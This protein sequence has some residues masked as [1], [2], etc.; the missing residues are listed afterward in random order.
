MNDTPSK[1]KQQ[2]ID[3]IKAATNILIAVSK[4]PSVD[5]LSA[6]I[7]MAAMLDK[8]GKHATAIFSGTLPAAISFLEPDKV[9]E[10]SVDSLRDFIIALD[11]EKADHVRVKVDGDVAKISIT[12]HRTT[13]TSEDLEFSQG[14]YN[15]ELVIALGVDKKD[16]LDMALASHGQILHDV[17]VVTLSVGG[18]VSDLGSI[19]W[20]ED[21][22]SCLCEMVTSLSEGLKA[23]EPILDKQISTALLTGIVAATERFSNTKTSPAVM[24]LA[25]QLMAAG[26]D[27]QLIASKLQET[28]QITTLTE[29]PS[30]KVTEPEKGQVFD[31][32]I[33]QTSTLPPETEVV[34]PTEALAAEKPVVEAPVIEK[35]AVKEPVAEEPIATSTLPEIKLDKPI[36]S[37]VLNSQPITDHPQIILD[38]QSNIMPDT[39]I[40]TSDLVSP[41]VSVPVPVEVVVAATPVVEDGLIADSF[42]SSSTLPN[43]ATANSSMQPDDDYKLIDI[44]NGDLDKENTSTL[45]PDPSIN[46]APISD[47]STAIN[48]ASQLAAPVISTENIAPSPLTELPLPPPL[49]D[50]STL[51]PQPVASFG[52]G[53][54][55]APTVSV[56]SDPSQF[57]IPGQ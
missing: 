31:L 10:N 2:I 52:S 44:F 28:H 39:S 29:N 40:K 35:P 48:S 4:D 43:V 50:F 37:D 46:T 6:A 57:K 56:P 21:S 7:G 15:V 27:Q 19:D 49:P 20:H 8:L 1:D 9:F 18:M 41:A 12:P 42:P 26:A 23:E 54:S 13:I 22:F 17:T 25:A 33:E 51:P 3:K 34:K 16:H 45:P 14:D 36:D 11:K 47:L 53:E 5:D 32:K 30:E 55:S 24:S 38:S